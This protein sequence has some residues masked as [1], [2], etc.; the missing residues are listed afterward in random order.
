MN[1]PRRPLHEIL[2]FAAIEVPEHPATAFW[3]RN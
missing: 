2:R 1:Y 3:E